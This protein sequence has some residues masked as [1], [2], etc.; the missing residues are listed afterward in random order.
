MIDNIFDKLHA[1]N[2]DA[3]H[4]SIYV[5]QLFNVR[6]LT[7]NNE[8]QEKTCCHK[9]QKIQR[10]HEIRQLFIIIAKRC[11]I[12]NNRLFI[13]FHR[14]RNKLIS[15]IQCSIYWQIEIYRCQSSWTKKIQRNI[16]ELQ[17][18]IVVCTTSNRQIITIL[19]KFC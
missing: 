14:R 3:L 17:K 12:V 4:V 19:Q 13:H 16:H 15:S 9:Y 6:C 7:W 1:Q 8:R 11:H 5:I 2:K 10:N 18:I